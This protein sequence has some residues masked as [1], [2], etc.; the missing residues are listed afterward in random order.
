[1]TTSRAGPLVVF[2]LGDDRKTRTGYKAEFLRLRMLPK[3]DMK[4]PTNSGER[5]SLA[6]LA[7]PVAGV[8]C[9]FG[10]FLHIVLSD[11]LL[12]SIGFHYSG[13]EGQFY[14][15]IHPGTVF[16]FISFFVLLWSHGNPL[17]EFLLI[18]WRYQVYMLFLLLYV[19]LFFYMLARSGYQGLE[20]P[21]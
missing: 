12:N 21:I 15:K 11:P 13:D 1:M 3:D 7:Y 17:R 6:G 8:I 18:S 20:P 4:I 5:A 9:L 16:I 14:E 2:H 10:F 19:L